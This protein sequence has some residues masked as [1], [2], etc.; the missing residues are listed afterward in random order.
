MCF[1]DIIPSLPQFQIHFPLPTGPSLCPFCFHSSS[2]ICA[3]HIFFGVWSSTGMWSTYQGLHS[4]K[5]KKNLFLPLPD[6]NNCSTTR[7]R[8]MCPTA[9]SRFCSYCHTI[10]SSYV[11]L[12]SLCGE[13]T[14]C[15]PSTPLVLTLFLPPLPK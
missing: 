15:S 10:V 1:K 2:P 7:S 4:L 5:K 12:P 9:L 14:I 6:A 13:D 11:Q 8:T 3:A